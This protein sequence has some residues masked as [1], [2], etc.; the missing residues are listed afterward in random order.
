MQFKKLNSNARIAA[1]LCWGPR[2]GMSSF[3]DESSARACF[4]KG[5][6]T[7]REPKRF[8]RCQLSADVAVLRILDTNGH[9]SNCCSWILSY[10]MMMKN[11]NSYGQDD[12][13]K[14]SIDSRWILFRT[15]L[16]HLRKIGRTHDPR[17]GASVRMMSTR[18]MGKYGYQ[19]GQ[20]WFA[21]EDWAIC[22]FWNPYWC[23]CCSRKTWILQYLLATFHEQ[24]HWSFFW[25]LWTTYETSV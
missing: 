2:N 14:C 9:L 6:T 21:G 19:E 10:I 1:W 3:F 18:I 17:Q 12:S 24:L 13:W 8:R 5:F 4:T 20:Q 15:S 11:V 7:S 23:I 16:G 22:A 25:R